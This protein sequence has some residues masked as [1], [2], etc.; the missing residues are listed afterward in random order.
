MGALRVGRESCLANLTLK[1]SGIRQHYNLIVMA[2]EKPTG[3]MRFNPFFEAVIE[4]EGTLIAVEEEPKLH[5]L[6]RDLS[7]AG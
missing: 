1:D 2:I 5:A 7:P 6:A 3:E 4:A